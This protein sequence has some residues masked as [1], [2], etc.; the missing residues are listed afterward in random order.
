M[1]V[2]NKT[3]NNAS[4][5][6]STSASDGAY[7][8]EGSLATTT[9][10]YQGPKGPD[11]NWTWLDHEPADTADA[12]E[13]ASTAQHA[14]ITRLQKA[15]DSRKKYEIHSLIVQSPWLKKVLDEYVLKDYPGVCC[16]LTRLEF[17][18]PVCTSVGETV[19]GK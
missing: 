9:T 5:L 19:R 11:K 14:L 6:N 10:L 1:A 4:S 3:S 17:E 15:E 8:P 2:S 7:A 18:A 16:S 12:A 13:N